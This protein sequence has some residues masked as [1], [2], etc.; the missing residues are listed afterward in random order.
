VEMK[1]YRACDVP[2][3]YLGWHS[4][5]KRP[6]SDKW[7]IERYDMD[8]PDLARYAISGL[9]PYLGVTHYKLDPRG[10]LWHIS[11]PL[12]Y[13]G[14]PAITRPLFA[15]SEDFG[16]T[17]RYV[18]DINY[19]P[20][21]FGDRL[22]DKRYGYTEPDLTFL[23]DGNAMALMRT[24]DGHGVGPMYAAYSSD[25]CATWSKPEIF[26]DLGVFPALLTLNNGVTLA[27][28]GR[29]GLYLRATADPAGRKWDDRVELVAPTPVFQQDTCAYTGMIA[30]DDNTAYLVYSDFQRPNA[31][32]TPVKTIMGRTIRAEIV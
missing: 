21:P 25:D 17:F 2:D 7:E 12:F 27:T 32:G 23:P 15:V 26:D 29:P 3:K 22:W 16:H 14:T 1:V 8:V 28:Y 4:E 30:V 9:F 10:R 11:Y 6:G 24:T 5:R 18:S 19:Q 31:K 13:D 20:D